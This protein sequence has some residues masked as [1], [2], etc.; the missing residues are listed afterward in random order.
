MAHGG[1]HARDCA[2]TG[3]SGL[4]GET[5]F[6]PWSAHGVGALAGGEAVLRA[7]ASQVRCCRAQSPKVCQAMP[8]KRR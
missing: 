8:G 7:S 6:V 5:Y 3:R 4:A 1:R 2:I